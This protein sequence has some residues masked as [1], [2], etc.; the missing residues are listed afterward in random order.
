M[1][2]FNPCDPKKKQGFRISSK[3][4]FLLVGTARFELTTSRTPSEP[5]GFSYFVKSN[6]IVLNSILYTK[7]PIHQDLLRSRKLPPSCH[8]L[9]VRVTLYLIV[10][11][12]VKIKEILPHFIRTTTNSYSPM[13]CTSISFKLQT[14][15]LLYVKLSHFHST[16]IIY[17]L[18]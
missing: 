3:A 18:L 14:G 15:S 12:G 5:R 10:I 6:Q 4:L 7:W 16:T 2:A 1:T 17:R 13:I 8:H 11:F 9:Y